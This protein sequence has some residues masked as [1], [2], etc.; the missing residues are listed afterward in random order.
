MPLTYTFEITPNEKEIID[1]LRT[2]KPYE[3]ITIMADAVGRPD[4]YILTR[5]S[6]ALLLKDK[7]PQPIRAKVHFQD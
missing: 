5:S 6:K 3:T 1:Q 7:D 4:S 2:L